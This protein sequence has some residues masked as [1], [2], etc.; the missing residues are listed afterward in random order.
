MFFLSGYLSQGL[1]FTTLIIKSI[2]K[3]LGSTTVKMDVQAF[4]FERGKTNGFQ[5]F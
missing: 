3:L 1:G 4:Y 5:K 2:R